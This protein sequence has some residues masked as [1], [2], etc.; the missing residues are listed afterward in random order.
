MNVN[1][2]IRKFVV[3]AV[4]GAVSGAF[5]ADQVPVA[6]VAP[7]A[8]KP[9]VTEP[10]KEGTPQGGTPEDADETPGAEMSKE[11]AAKLVGGK[12]GG[13]PDLAQAGGQSPRPVARV[14][15]RTPTVRPDAS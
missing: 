9:E 15:L 5:A 8:L 14:P 1:A 10:V 3:I 7:G 6:P 11:E 2:C 13:K 4:L 12:G